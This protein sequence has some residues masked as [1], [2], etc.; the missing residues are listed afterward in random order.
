MKIGVADYGMMMWD[1]GLFDYEQRCL[2][3]KSIGYD[4][5]ERIKPVSGED[6]VTIAAMLK[7]HR[8]DFGTCLTSTAEKSI[9]W[10]AALG[11]TYVWTDVNGKD[12]DTYC[13]QVN[14]QA[15]ACERYGINVAIHN[16]LGSLVE[17]Q[18]ELEA[19]LQRCPDCR[20]ILDTGHLN[21]AGGD[22]LEIIEKYFDRIEVMHVK[23]W[24]ESDSSADQWFKRGRFCELG[25]G[26]IDLDNDA[27]VKL[28][29]KKGYDGWIFV[30]HDTHL[31]DPLEDLKISMEYLRNS[32][33]PARG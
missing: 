33:I 16:H 6:A 12:F 27:V 29:L 24:I 4:G 31:Q 26:N 5:T 7:K 3:L 25:A 20:M 17:S 11:K 19:F 15:K 18:E 8:L 10:T 14:I 2:D 21:A 23:D 9:Q 30:E 22:S 13:R 28:L 1:G 32:G